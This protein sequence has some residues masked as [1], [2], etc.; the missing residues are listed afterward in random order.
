MSIPNYDVKE[1]YTGTGSLAS[2]TFDFRIVKKEQLL[3]IVVDVY[4]VEKERLRGTDATYISDVLFDPILGGG[5]VQ[6]LSNLP[7]GEKLIVL[8]ADDE[9]SQLF[10]FKNKTSFTLRMFESALD[11]IMQAVQR[12]VYRSNQSVKIHDLDNELTFNSQLPSGIATKFDKMIKVKTDGTGVDFGMTAQ[13][14]IDAAVAEAL[15]SISS[16]GGGAGDTT[17]PYSGFSARFGEPFDTLGTN[18]TL[19]QILDLSYLG[20][21]LSFSASGSGTLREKGNAVTAS[22]LTA[23]VTKK[24]DD[25]AK[26]EFFFNNVSINIQEPPSNIGSGST[27]YGWT[28]S[29]S[30]SP[31]TFKAEITDTGISGGPTTVSSSASFSFVYPYYEGVGA[32]GLD[33]TGIVANLNK[34]VRASSNSVGVTSSPVGQKIYFCYP[35]AYPALT[36]ILDPSNFEV[37]SAF[38]Q[39]SVSITGLDGTPQTYRVYELN[40]NTTQ[41]AYT[42]TFKR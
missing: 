37:L 26:I 9:P 24:S 17:T 14:I 16:S 25:I 12:L 7:S 19:L 15:S 11:N 23:S 4:G 13:E 30:D 20:P 3:I 41:T 39:R 29:F 18:Q 38:T 27:V 10:E 6:L 2:Y 1:V 8:L 28:G 40:T 5:T 32:A 42:I 35:A 31:A 33:A 36:S 34:V 21:A 22:T